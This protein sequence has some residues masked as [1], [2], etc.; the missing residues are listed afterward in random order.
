M[1]GDVLSQSEIDALLSAL[2]TG[3]MSA[4]EMKAEEEKKKSRFMT[5]SVPSVF[6]RIKS[7][8]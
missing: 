6:Q 5:S 4:D 2:S 1:P 8:V 7:G 3:E